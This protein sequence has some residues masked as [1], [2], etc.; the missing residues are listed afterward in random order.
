MNRKQKIVLIIGAVL[1]LIVIFTTP[2]VVTQP[3]S[4]GGLQFDADFPQSIDF[5]TG[6]LRGAGVIVATLFVCY[7]LKGKDSAS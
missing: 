5:Q 6:V 1:L 7:A 2:Q 3:T 4:G